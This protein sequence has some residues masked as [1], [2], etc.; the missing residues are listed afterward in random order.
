MPLTISR[1]TMEK[2]PL[3]KDGMAKGIEMEIEK[4][5]EK[6]KF[7][8]KKEDVLNLHKELNLE[9]EKIADILE[10]PLSFVEDVLK[11]GK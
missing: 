11:E 8:A 7:E 2:H 1:E 4:E 5:I 3:Y 9:H 6:G 10:L